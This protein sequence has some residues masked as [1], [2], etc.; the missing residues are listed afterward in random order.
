MA[1]DFK[2]HIWERSQ[3]EYFLIYLVFSLKDGASTLSLQESLGGMGLSPSS[4]SWLRSSRPAGC[5]SAPSELPAG[6]RRTTIAISLLINRIHQGPQKV[7]VRANG[8]R[9]CSREATVVWCHFL[10]S[11]AEFLAILPFIYWT[12]RLISHSSIILPILVFVFPW[13][14][15]NRKNIDVNI[16]FSCHTDKFISHDCHL[17]PFRP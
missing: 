16:I 5:C 11:F 14:K 4:L 15:N 13:I 7:E 17:K 6:K 9:A 12:W 1:T 8:M 2:G 10:L 3:N